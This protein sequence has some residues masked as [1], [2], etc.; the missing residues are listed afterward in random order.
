MQS[1]IEKLKALAVENDDLAE[2]TPEESSYDTDTFEALRDAYEN[3]ARIVEAAD[4]NTAL[5][6]EAFTQVMAALAPL[7]PEARLRVLKAV[8]ILIEES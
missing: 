2:H 8:R 1:I 5:M 4:K 7:P 3:A 6:Q